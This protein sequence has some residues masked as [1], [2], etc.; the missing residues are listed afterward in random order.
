[1]K[2]ILKM[3]M[4]YYSGLQRQGMPIVDQGFAYT[5]GSTSAE[6]NMEILS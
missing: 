5:V 2:M 4:I 3:K 1:M 6:K